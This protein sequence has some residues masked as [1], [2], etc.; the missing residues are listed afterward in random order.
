[1]EY[2]SAKIEN[3]ELIVIKHAGHAV[4]LEK[5]NIYCNIV[6]GFLL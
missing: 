1:M 3:S 2:I 4:F 5:I 6:K